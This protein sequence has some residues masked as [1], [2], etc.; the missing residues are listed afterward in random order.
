ME[1]V[2]RSSN[3]E[4]SLFKEKCWCNWI[5]IGEKMKLDL[6]LYHT[7]ILHKIVKDLNITAKTTNRK[8]N[9]RIDLYNPGFGNG[10]IDVTFKA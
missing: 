7:K 3:G 8:K 4:R 5:S 6:T 10:F 9:S 2:S 1:R